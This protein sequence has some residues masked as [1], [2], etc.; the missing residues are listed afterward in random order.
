MT[1]AK[2]L[3]RIKVTASTTDNKHW[4]PDSVQIGR[5]S[6]KVQPFCGR[7]FKNRKLLL[8]KKEIG[9]YWLFSNWLPVSDF[10]CWFCVS[11]ENT[12]MWPLN[13]S[14]TSAA[15][16]WIIFRMRWIHRWA[17]C[18]PW[19]AQCQPPLSDPVPPSP[20]REAII[21][22]K[23]SFFLTNCLNFRVSLTDL[24]IILSNLARQALTHFF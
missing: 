8:D 7:N 16:S 17:L 1:I 19:L 18:A 24:R 14:K 20:T 10:N 5:F 3:P 13:A 21:Y 2:C 4:H 12:L 15:V 23:C 11:T 22:Q 6:R 9:W